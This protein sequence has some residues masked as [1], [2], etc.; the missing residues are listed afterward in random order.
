MANFLNVMTHIKSEIQ[1]AERTP[2]TINTK[3]KSM[4]CVSYSNAKKRKT[5]SK[6]IGHFEESQS[7]KKTLYL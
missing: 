3:K 4:L 1:E 6:K 7:G 5:N 2:R